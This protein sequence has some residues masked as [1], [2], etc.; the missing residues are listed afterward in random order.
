[1]VKYFDSRMVRWIGWAGLWSTGHPELRSPD[2]WMTQPWT[3]ASSIALFFISGLI[4]EIVYRKL[5]KAWIHSR[6]PYPA[7]IRPECPDN[8]WISL[9]DGFPPFNSKFEVFCADG[10]TRNAMTGEDTKG[11]VLNHDFDVVD[12]KIE[13]TEYLRRIRPTHWRNFKHQ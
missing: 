12:K 3:I 1:V 4:L 9:L 13:Y 2:V 6:K 5:A 11:I 7:A 10:K 8:P